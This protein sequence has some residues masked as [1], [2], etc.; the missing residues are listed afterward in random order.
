[1]CPGLLAIFANATAISPLI[2]WGPPLLDRRYPPSPLSSALRAPHPLFSSAQLLEYPLHLAVD[3]RRHLAAELLLQNGALVD[4]IDAKRNTALHIAAAHGDD[5]LAALLLEFGADRGRRN[6][7]HRTPLEI[8]QE[9][10]F[11]Q[12]AA[13]IASANGSLLEGRCG[14]A[15][16]P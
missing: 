4:A 14:P 15:A 10:G 5:A 7:G 6:V 2:Y 12:V 9:K 11:A 13:T 8:A 3:G 16:L 1:M